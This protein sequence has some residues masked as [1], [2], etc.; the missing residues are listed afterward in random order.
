VIRPP[1][2]EGTFFLLPVETGQYGVGLVA[3][4]PRRGG[5]LLGYFFGPRRTTPPTRE[6]L[7]SRVAPQ[8]ILVARFRD[9]ALFRG[10]WKTLQVMEPFDRDAWPIPAF[11]RFDGS[12]TATPGATTITDW[13]IQYG[14]DNLITPA[15][16]RPA[17]SA[18][19]RLRED[20]VYDPASLCREVGAWLTAAVPSADDNLWR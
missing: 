1:V 12:I 13:R 18:D 20:T 16:E 9:Q 19:L 11:H 2:R 4:A 8:A 17:T 7:E 14:D 5:V 3:R 6:W 10:E 15:D